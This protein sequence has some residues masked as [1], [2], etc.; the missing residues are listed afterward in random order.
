MS[1][2]SERDGLM[3]SILRLRGLNKN[4]KLDLRVSCKVGLLLAMSVE[5]CLSSEEAPNVMKK[6]MSDEDKV[7]MA[8]LAKE[9]LK[10]AEAEEFYDLIKKMTKGWVDGSPWKAVVGLFLADRYDD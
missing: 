5:Y 8:E 3:E 10:L 9:I 4:V 2:V 7:K 1:S 6:I